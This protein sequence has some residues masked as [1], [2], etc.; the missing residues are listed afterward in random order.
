MTWL[1]AFIAG[2][3]PERIHR[4]TVSGWTPR[5][6]AI[7]FVERSFTLTG[8][9]LHRVVLCR[10]EIVEIILRSLPRLSIDEQAGSAAAAERLRFS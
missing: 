10:K 1:V 5:A 3:R 9:M 2:S 8:Q 4:R 6:V 7:C